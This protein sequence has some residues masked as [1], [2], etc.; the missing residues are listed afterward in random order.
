MEVFNEKEL[1]TTTLLKSFAE[2]NHNDVMFELTN[3]K[4][5]ASKAVL[6]ARSDY[7]GTMFREDFQFKEEES[8]VQRISICDIDESEKNIRSMI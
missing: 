7:F 2:K 8:G 6:A 5:F 4:L 1:V 3:G